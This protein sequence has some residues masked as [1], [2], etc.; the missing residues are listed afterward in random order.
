MPRLEET[1]GEYEMA[2]VP[3]SLCRVDGSLYIPTDKASLTCLIE[4]ANP[5]PQLETPPATGNLHRIL[6]IDAMAIVQGNYN[7]N[8]NYNNILY[9][10]CIYDLYT[11]LK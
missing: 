8:N 10:F 2:V 5:Q 9:K 11:G 3:H 4:E 7:N 6:V 1:I